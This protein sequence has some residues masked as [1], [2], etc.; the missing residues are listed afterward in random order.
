M[1]ARVTRTPSLASEFPRFRWPTPP[2]E[3]LAGRRPEDIRQRCALG[4]GESQKVS[5]PVSRNRLTTYDEATD[6]WKLVPGAYTAMAG[7]SSEDL[8]LQQQVSLR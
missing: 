7:G 2:T 1:A 5:I 8:P 6:S 3:S 4:P